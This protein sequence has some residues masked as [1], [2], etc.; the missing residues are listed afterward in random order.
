[1]SGIRKGDVPRI[2][3]KFRQLPEAVQRELQQQIRDAGPRVVSEARA[4]VPVDLGDLKN[5]ITLIP[6]GKFGWAIDVMAK[7]KRGRHAFNYGWFVEFGTNRAVAVTI[8]RGRSKKAQTR[9]LGANAQPFLL[10]A[11]RRVMRPVMRQIRQAIRGV[12]RKHSIRG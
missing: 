9:K 3:Q 10:P 6:K 12:V 4:R 1:M 11:F 2:T 7:A 5:S 8:R